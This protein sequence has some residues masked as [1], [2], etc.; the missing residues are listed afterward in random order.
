MIFF[1]WALAVWGLDGEGS[2]D[3]GEDPARWVGRGLGAV[4]MGSGWKVRYSLH[5]RCASLSPASSVPSVFLVSLLMT[6]TE[7]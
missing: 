3:R 4:W 2:T 6:L 1:R 5:A 7:V